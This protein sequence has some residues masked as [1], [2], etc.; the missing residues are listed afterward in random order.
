MTVLAMKMFNLSKSTIV[1]FR[2]A[3]YTTFALIAFAANSI[4]CRLALSESSIDPASFTTI[5]LVSGAVLIL[6]IAR[7]TTKEREVKHPG[8]WISATMLFLYAAAFSYAYVSLSAGSGA[9]ILFASVQATMILAGLWKGERPRILEW[10]GLFLAL[11]GLVYL[12]MPG[13]EAPPLVGAFLMTI[14]G[15]SWGVYSLRG[16]GVDNPVAVTGDN[17]LRSVPPMIAISLFL[18]PNLDISMKGVILAF[19]SGA[20]TS[21]IGYVIW[22]AVLGDLSA[23]RAA[24]VQLL[25]PVIA[26]LGGVLFLTELIT[27]RLIFSAILIISGVGS[28]LFVRK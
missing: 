7:I 1:S 22:Y 21:G 8:N 24:M 15:V 6:L 13:L 28:C 2:T 9:L 3:I 18:I 10:C 27:F 23:T 16:R 25:V 26:A 4:L 19:L 5:R 20:V 12:V 17:F 11:S 14:A